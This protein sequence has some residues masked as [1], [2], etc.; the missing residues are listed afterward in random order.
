M[1]RKIS[2]DQLRRDIFK[3]LK[4]HDLLTIEQF[5]KAFP[6][7][8][9]EIFSLSGLNKARQDTFDLCKAQPNKEAEIISKLDKEFLTLK[10]VGIVLLI[11]SIWYEGGI[12]KDAEYRLKIAELSQ[13]ASEA[14][15]KA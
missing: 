1:A 11:V 3:P 12:A 13:K 2:Q 10:K 7:S 15:A 14:E 9:F 5:N 4:E 8:E 6:T